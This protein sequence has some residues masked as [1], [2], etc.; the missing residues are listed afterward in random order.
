VDETVWRAARDRSAGHLLRLLAVLVALALAAAACSDD[1]GGDGDGDAAEPDGTTTT[2][3]PLGDPDG[4]DPLP[5]LPDDVALPIVFV[6]GFA[7]S[8]QQYESQAMRFV[9]NGYPQERILAYDHD[10]AGVDMEGYVAGLAEVV[11]EALA[12]FDAEQVYLVGHSRGTFV[13]GLYLGDPA[14]AAKVAKYV[15]IDGQPCPEVDGVPCTAP[16]QALFPGQSHVEVATSAESFAMQYEF[17]VGDAPEV[18]D[19]VPQREPVE[20]SGRAVNFPANTGRESTLEIWAVDAETGARVGDEP[21]ATF[22]LGPDG[23]FGPVELETGAHYEY[24]LSSD[25]TP[26][27]HHLYLQPYLR[28][29]HL[30]RL[31]SSPPD[32]ATRANTNLG[33]GHSAV[34]AI[35][36][37]E[38]HAEAAA[39]G[40]PDQLLLSVD[41]GE[42]VDAVTD[43]VGNGGIGLHLHDDAATPGETTLGP[44]PYFADQPFQSGIDVFLPSS[45]DGSGTI[46]VTNIPRGDTTDPQV[47]N[48]PNWPST[49]H[50]ISV[51]F[52]DW[53]VDGAT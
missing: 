18:V 1:A 26:V 10:G 37:R 38:W 33:D 53:P 40:G 43:F 30:V 49:N 29:S 34:I 13:S 8:A 52:T 32:G 42:P 28:S 47:L 27:T 45:V 22:E 48:V 51:V 20:I 19:I 35:R 11:D 15:A 36:M 16:T 24:A 41:G 44:L 39:D 2:E 14:N 9:A 5:P 21:H 50:A 12:T 4:T 6:H 23:G 31:L 7:G 25:E 17:L 3:A 46:T